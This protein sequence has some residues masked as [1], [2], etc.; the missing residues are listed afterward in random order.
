M[1]EHKLS[2]KGLPELSDAPLSW[3][4]PELDIDQDLLFEGV[5][6]RRVIAFL[7]DL[8]I[9]G[10]IFAALWAIVFLTLGLLSGL[11]TLSPLIPVIYHTLMISSRRSATIGMQFMGIEVRNQSGKRPELLQAFAMT[12]L[13]YLSVTV[14]SML[15]LIVALF[16]DKRRCAHDI[17]SGTFVINSD[18]DQF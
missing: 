16:N 10:V 4:R 14:T 7:I 11:L 6:W 15:I 9:L 17:L 8:S 12:A 5:T 3:S 18:P 1:E 2:G 13:F